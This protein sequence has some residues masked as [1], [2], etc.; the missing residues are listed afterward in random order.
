MPRFDGAD[1]EVM[2]RVWTIA[3]ALH[4]C[5]PAAINS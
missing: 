1:I 5:S 4:N 3:G 2:D